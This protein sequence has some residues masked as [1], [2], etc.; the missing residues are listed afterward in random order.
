MGDVNLQ[1]RVEII[2]GPKPGGREM[3]QEMPLGVCAQM[4]EDGKW[5]GVVTL[6]GGSGSPLIFETPETYDDAGVAARAIRERLA[7]RLGS[8]LR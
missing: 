2:G 6:G 1:R 8:L 5:K 3:H 7:E 4:T